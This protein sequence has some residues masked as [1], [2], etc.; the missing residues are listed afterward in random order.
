MLILHLSD[1]HFRHP[2]CNTHADPDGPYRTLM[3]GDIRFMVDKLGTRIDAIVVT[4]DIACRGR[5]E[6]FMAADTW[7]TG[8]ASELGNPRSTIF[9]VP[10]NHDV[11]R[12]ISRQRDVRN[13]QHMVRNANTPPLR[14]GE[15]KSQLEHAATS[16][17]I[18]LPIEA[19]ND[20]AR[21]FDCNLF[22]PQRNYWR[23]DMPLEHGVKLRLHGWNSTLLSGF[24][25]DDDARG[26]MFIS[27]LQTVV[28][29]ED[30]VVNAVLA[31][32]PPGWCVD[33]DDIDE[34][35][36][37][38]AQLHLFGHKH[39]QRIDQHDTY[40]RYAAGAVNPNPDE[41]G[42]EPGYNLIELKVVPKNLARVLEVRSHVRR[43]RSG[44]STFEYRRPPTGATEWYFK[45]LPIRGAYQTGATTLT[46]KV[47]PPPLAAAA[48]PAIATPP[49][50]TVR[51]RDLVYRFWS[52]PMSGRRDIAIALG[53]LEPGDMQLKESERYG[54]ALLRAKERGLIDR[55]AAEIT[56]NEIKQ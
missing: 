40:I 21:K 16:R 42:W 27:R 55:L 53:L 10:G 56:K 25:G 36:C 30:G 43:Y 6:E 14:E 11:D 2:E 13:V 31:H 23:N 18:Y 44:D 35:I 50:D 24:G 29:P 41:A 47:D 34:K 45:E 39:R 48:A 15:L 19:Y 9:V 1:I 5:T 4:G 52:L 17:S 54:R 8:L 28:H 49:A 51:D 37:A 12:G 32:H 26:S 7:L 20:F 46:P 33:E 3:E 22:A 38:F